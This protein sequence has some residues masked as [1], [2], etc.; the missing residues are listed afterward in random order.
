MARR[1]IRRIAK[2]SL[3]VFSTHPVR[4]FSKAR[5]ILSI[6]PRMET[7]RFFDTTHEMEF[8]PGGVWRFVMHGPNGRDYQNKV[9]YVEVAEPERL[10]YDHVSESQF[11][12][13]VI[14]A[15][16]QDEHYS[17]DALRFSRAAR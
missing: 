15:G 1:P 7:E 9:V 4:S 17:A 14:F 3:A 13:A 6:S 5:Q 12:M 8:K 11:R 16:R 10:V 2:L